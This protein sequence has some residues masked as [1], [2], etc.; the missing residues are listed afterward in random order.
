MICQFAYRQGNTG[1]FHCSLGRFGGSPYLGN[2]EKC[3]EQGLNKDE[4]SLAEKAKSLAASVKTWV[5]SGLQIA[6]EDQVNYRLEICKSC[7]FW[8]ASGFARTGSCKKCGCS[9]QAKLRMATSK[10]PI[11][12]WGAIAL[13][14]PQ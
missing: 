7:E 4:P 13:E 1:P 2:C 8:N 14:K 11:D 12:K 10:C 3:I 9:T 5:G 6:T